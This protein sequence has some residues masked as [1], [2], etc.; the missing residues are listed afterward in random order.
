MCK[1]PGETRMSALR[2]EY[3]KLLSP[4][5]PFNLLNCK[6]KYIQIFKCMQIFRNVSRLTCVSIQA[7]LGC[8]RRGKNTLNR[9][10]PFL[11]LAYENISSS[12][13]ASSAVILS[14]ILRFQLMNRLS[15][16][17][18]VSSKNAFSLEAK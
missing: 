4:I 11:L 10:L 16:T 13:A 9:S 6:Y 5:S 2:K 3:I 12:S 1:Y 14:L 17:N 15:C 8:R 18:L 7:R